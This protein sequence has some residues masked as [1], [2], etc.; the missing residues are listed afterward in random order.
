MA[1][2]V[3][4]FQIPHIS[5]DNHSLIPQRRPRSTSERDTDYRRADPKWSPAKDALD[6]VR[7]QL[8]MITPAHVL[9]PAKSMAC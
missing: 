2:T 3:R 8:R 7:R 4:S 1:R 9:L 5:V 6:R